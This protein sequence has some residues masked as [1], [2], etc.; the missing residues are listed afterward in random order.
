MQLIGTDSRSAI[1][2]NWSFI[3]LIVALSFLYVRWQDQLPVLAAVKASGVVTYMYLA[4]YLIAGEKEPIW[5]EPLLRWYCL[6]IGLVLFSAVWSIN[7]APIFLSQSMIVWLLAYIGPIIWLIKTKRDI[8]NFAKAWV[9][10]H[11]IVALIVLKN[12][13]VGTGSFLL[14][15][16]D[17]AL[18]LGM[19][20]PYAYFLSRYP[21]LSYKWR[22]F[23]RLAALTMIVGVVASFSR[24]G[25]LGLVAAFGAMWWFTPNRMR[26]LLIGLLVLFAMSGAL[27]S[28]LPEGYVEDMATIQDTEN[29]T[30]VERFHSWETAYYMW[31]DHPILG[32]GAGN[33]P[34]NTLKYQKYSSYWKG[35]HLTRSLAGR[36]AHSF[37]F[38]LIAELGLV[39]TFLYGMIVWG[40]IGRMLSVTA[41][42]QQGLTE[43][44]ENPTELH[45]LLVKAILS[46]LGVFL[47][48]AAFLTVNYYPHIFLMIALVIALKRTLPE[49]H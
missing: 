15:E 19:G 27:L 38:T 41:L 45:E 7:I 44:L 42:H 2:T 49:Q 9:V 10:I 13:G 43:G 14:D 32:V 37:Y 23:L 11:F 35:V 40:I 6:L 34:W 22:M 30:R 5:Q 47:V 1:Q 17:V 8:E 21:N 39:G 18:A 33:Y 28:T 46:A 36:T 48:T 3:F 24:G 16:N 12:G 31:K 4:W 20:I 29:S 25:F 26:N